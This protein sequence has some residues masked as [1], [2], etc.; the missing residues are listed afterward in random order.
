MND[1]PV[2]GIPES[3]IIWNFGCAGQLPDAIRS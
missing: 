2:G 1:V 3:C